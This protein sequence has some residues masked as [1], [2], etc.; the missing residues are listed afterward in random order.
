MFDL[1]DQ[2]GFQLH[3]V[4]LL[5]RR[6]LIRCLKPY[7]LSPEQW[8]ILATLWRKE[9]LSQKE[10]MNLTLQDAPSVSRMLQRMAHGG[11]VQLRKS[12]ADGRTMA[13]TL[14]AKGRRM[15]TILPGLVLHHFQ[16]VLESVSVRRRQALLAILREFRS[17]LGDT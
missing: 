10:I 2:I 15:E 17:A 13:I 1:E 8:Q 5:F 12:E 9:G 3:R 7:E 14:T 11:F 4:A 6:E 16:P